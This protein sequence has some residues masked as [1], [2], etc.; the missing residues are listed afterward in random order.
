MET[1]LGSDPHLHREAC[2]RL[3]G[4]YQAAVDCA[5]LP[6]WVT[7]ERIA[8]ERVELYIS[9]PPPGENIPISVDT[10]PVDELV[11]T[12]DNIEWAVKRLQ[13]HCSGGASGMWAEHLKGWLAAEKRKEREEAAAKKEHPVE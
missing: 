10:L 5:P 8:S 1:L 12:E 7:L 2:H 4:W 9:V 6:A 11:P 13:N 3:K